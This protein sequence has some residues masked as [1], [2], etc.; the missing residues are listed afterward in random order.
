VT[1]MNSMLFIAMAFDQSLGSWDISS[2]MDMD[3]MLLSTG[4]SSANYSATL[5]GWAALPTVPSNITLDAGGQ[6]YCPGAA[7]EAWQRLRD[8][9]HWD[10]Q[11]HK[12]ATDCGGGGTDGA[13]ITTWRTTAADES[14]TIRTNPSVTGYNYTVNW[15]DG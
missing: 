4:L 11:N 6:E 12:E 5:I 10:I 8:E 14:I 13:F 1:T 3:D 2:V 7:A 9:Y 15:G